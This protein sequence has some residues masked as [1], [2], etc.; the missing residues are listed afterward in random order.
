MAALSVSP[1][2]LRRIAVIGSSESDIRELLKCENILFY[3]VDKLLGE[4]AALFERHP[5]HSADESFLQN[6]DHN[7][8]S[9]TA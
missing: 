2:V 9:R 3:P 7:L 1:A 4:G 5:H 6:D 8:F